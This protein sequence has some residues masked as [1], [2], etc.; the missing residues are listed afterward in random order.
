MGRSNGVYVSSVQQPADFIPSYH[1]EISESITTLQRVGNHR[2]RR[3]WN[4]Q[5][6]LCELCRY[7][8]C[9]R[10]IEFHLFSWKRERIVSVFVN[11]YSSVNCVGHWCSADSDRVS[12][13]KPSQGRNRCTHS[14]SNCLMGFF[15]CYWADDSLLTSETSYRNNPTALR[16]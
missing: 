15:H 7:G 8:C 4:A 3:E 11:V 9:F 2:N 5:T 13:R 6:F 16:N 1:S 10:S 14:I 12:G